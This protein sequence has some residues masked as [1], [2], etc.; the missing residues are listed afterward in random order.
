[1]DHGGYSVTQYG[2]DKMHLALYILSVCIDSIQWMIFECDIETRV[3]V[4]NINE[5]NTF[6]SDQNW[7]HLQCEDRKTL[8]QLWIK[9]HFQHNQG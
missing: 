5:I 7:L 9:L 1:M 2:W 6:L 3:D 4:Q 8:F